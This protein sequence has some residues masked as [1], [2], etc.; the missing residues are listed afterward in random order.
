MGL[1][2][3]LI[4]KMLIDFTKDNDSID[5]K[6]KKAN[7]AVNLIMN[8]TLK[9]SFERFK[10]LYTMNPKAWNIES[11]LTVT[12]NYGAEETKW[13]YLHNNYV[14]YTVSKKQY[15]EFGYFDSFKYKKWRKEQLAMYPEELV[16]AFQK[17]IDNYKEKMAKEFEKQVEQIE[18]YMDEHPSEDEQWKENLKNVLLR[19]FN[20]IEERK[21][22]Q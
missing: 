11:E 21:K 5:D 3:Y 17:D 19:I 14:E 20:R 22:T 10:S 16:A 2:F 4:V 7:E 6:I 13:N 9:I 12:Y 18:K 8:K 15:F 1:M